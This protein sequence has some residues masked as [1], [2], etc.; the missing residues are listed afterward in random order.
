MIWGGYMAIPRGIRNKNP[1]NIRH[2]DNW[3]GMKANQSDDAFVQFTDAKYGIRAMVKVL[4]SYRNRG[5]V[6]LERIISVWAPTNENNTEAYIKSVM[7]ATGWQRSHVV[8]EMEGDY[9]TLIPA[10][11]KHEN[12]IN[13]Y[14]T[15][16][17]KEGYALA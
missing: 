3:E 8:V 4:R 12:G 9:L 13:P 10:I 11:I 7:K 2:G 17:L 6:T 5:I 14:S 15:D 1:G 16:T